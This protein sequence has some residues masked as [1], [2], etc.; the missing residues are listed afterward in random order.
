MALIL[1]MPIAY[2]KTGCYQLF[3]RFF[4]SFLTFHYFTRWWGKK[5]W[6]FNSELQANIRAHAD[7]PYLEL[8]QSSRQFKLYGREYPQRDH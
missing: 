1:Y 2:I 8:E 4:F 6:T 7:N 5:E 3:F